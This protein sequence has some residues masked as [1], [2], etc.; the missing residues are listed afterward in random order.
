MRP[1]A[2]IIHEA[3][4]KIPFYEQ[5]IEFDFDADSHYWATNPEEEGMETVV[6]GLM[7]ECY[8]HARQ[9][10]KRI[11][12]YQE[13]GTVYILLEHQGAPIESLEEMNARLERLCKTGKFENE[14][15]PSGTN[16]AAQMLHHLRGTVKL[17][18]IDEDGYR[19]RTQIAVPATLAKGGRVGMPPY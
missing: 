14:D 6:F 11:R 13:N 18:N 10:Q 7:R 5:E 2:I 15:R 9:S 12:T 3:L 19:V 16:F 4:S 8:R 1:L 17:E